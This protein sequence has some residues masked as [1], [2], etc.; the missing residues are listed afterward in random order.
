[1]L[2]KK[3]IVLAFKLQYLAYGNNWNCILILSFYYTSS[4][5]T[6]DFYCNIVM[7]KKPYESSCEVEFDIEYLCNL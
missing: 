6:H 5:F 2:K 4:G 7:Y 3:T 1:M